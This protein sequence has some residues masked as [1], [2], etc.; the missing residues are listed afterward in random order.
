[1]FLF[2]SIIRAHGLPEE[3]TIRVQFPFSIRTFRLGNNLKKLARVFA[4]INQFVKK[5]CTFPDSWKKVVLFPDPLYFHAFV[6]LEKLQGEKSWN[7][8]TILER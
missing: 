8:D 3:T 5:D 4:L 2:F 6:Y 7:S 1:M